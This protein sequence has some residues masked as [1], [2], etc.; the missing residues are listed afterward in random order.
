MLPASLARPNTNKPSPKAP[1]GESRVPADKAK[2]KE[3]DK[4]KEQPMQKGPVQNLEIDP[5]WA[6]PTGST[7]EGL[8]QAPSPHLGGWPLIKV[9]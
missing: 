1:V 2:E 5:R 8:F 3:R 4:A 9:P 6:L 7:Y